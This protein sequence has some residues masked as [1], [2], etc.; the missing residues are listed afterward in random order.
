M[1]NSETQTEE[2]EIV[3]ER[4]CYRCDMPCIDEFYALF[5]LCPTCGETAKEEWDYDVSLYE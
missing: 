1:D 3:Y 4:T 5:D 2:V